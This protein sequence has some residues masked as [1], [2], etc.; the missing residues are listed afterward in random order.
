[1]SSKKYASPLHLE[2]KPSRFLFYFLIALHLFAFILLWFLPLFIAWQ[3]LISIFIIVGGI[4]SVKSYATKQLPSSVV[5]LVWDA[6]EQ[7]FIQTQEGKTQPVILNGNSYVHPKFTLLNFK[8][9]NKW[10][11]KA[12]ILL[13]D[14]VDENSFRRLRVRLKIT[15][16]M[17]KEVIES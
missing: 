13:W 2:I 14:N 16:L 17:D 7:W 6:D 4:Y 5:G 8:Q 1:M 11:S 12:V 3:V 9:E 15:N 10:F